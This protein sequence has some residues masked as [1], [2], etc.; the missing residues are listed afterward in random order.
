MNYIR[1]FF[2]KE[3]TKEDEKIDDAELM[4]QD[5]MK[6][7]ERL[8]EINEKYHHNLLDNLSI[9]TRKPYKS[10]PYINHEIILTTENEDV[11]FFFNHYKPI[12]STDI[13]DGIDID[14]VVKGK[15]PAHTGVSVNDFFEFMES[16][17]P[18]LWNSEFREK[19]IHG[20]DMEQEYESIYHPP[21]KGG[22]TKNRKNKKRRTLKKRGKQTKI[23]LSSK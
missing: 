16:I 23:Y 3:E 15:E 22:K 14:L 5:R 21:F 7:L 6:F 10:G 12:M 11:R 2:T 19:M 13:E 4:K 1:S 18:E 17:F 20:L 9:R 8:D